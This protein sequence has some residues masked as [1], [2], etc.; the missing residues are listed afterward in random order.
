MLN[1]T[2]TTDTGV[3]Q[4]NMGDGKSIDEGASKAVGDQKS[5]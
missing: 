2:Q 5:R 3:E 1:N 4:E